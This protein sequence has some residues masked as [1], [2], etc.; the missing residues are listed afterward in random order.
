VDLETYVA[1][2]LTGEASTLRSPAALAAMAVVARTWAL[3]SRGRHRAQGFDFCSLTH[4]QVF[5]LPSE[6]EDAPSPAV[7]EAVAITRSVVLKYRGQL[8]DPYFSANCGG[9]TAAASDVWPDRLQ[10]YLQSVR[11]PYCAGS[12]QSSWQQTVPLE[13]VTWV[14]K[15]RL[16]LALE[17]P[18]RDLQVAEKDTSGRARRLR[19]VAL[20]AGRIDA[21]Q[22]RYA[23]N[24]KLG[25]NTLKS[26]LYSV[27]RKNT[28]LVFIGRG[29]GHGVGLCQ[30]GAE[31]MGHMG[32]PHERILTHYFPGTTVEQLPAPNV[33][34]ILSSEHFELIFPPGQRAWAEETLAGLEAARHS[35][36]DRAELLPAKVRAR[37]WDTTAEFIRASGQLGWVAASNDGR[38]IE[39]QPLRTL[40]RKGI[41]TST[42]RHELTHLVVHRLRTP[43]VP[44]WY[45][46]GLVLYLTGEPVGV[47]TELRD[48]SRSLEESVSR[49][50][51]EAEIKAAYARA[52]ERVRDLARRRGAAALWQVLQ[53]PSA[54]DV[55][56]FRG[57]P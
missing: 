1:G 55:L 21:N 17:G 31:Q 49:P 19:V 44:R 7:A 11:D 5:R 45:E 53:Y 39:L 18:I 38:T 41:L 4:C 57:R 13:T 34:R 15:N 37:T 30:A 35:L 36:R 24:R 32:I 16:K 10:P 40:K 28:A 56:W 3:R 42:L 48:T 14:L 43:E 47:S 29:L 46:E 26:S 54:E 50:R 22:F 33:P 51:S 9:I 2:V 23:I 12:E 27:H 25:W 6:P 8:A 20:S 52:L